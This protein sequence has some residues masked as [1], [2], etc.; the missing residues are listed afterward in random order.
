[1]A[2]KAGEVDNLKAE[3]ARLEEEVARLRNDPR[4]TD[5]SLEIDSGQLAEVEG[6]N[7]KHLAAV[8]SEAT[9]AQTEV[10]QRKRT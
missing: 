5:I 9:K 7:L 10:S 1:V 2:T 6:L 4:L 8:K 3:L